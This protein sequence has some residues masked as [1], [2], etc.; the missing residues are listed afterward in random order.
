[1]KIA[2]IV[3]AAGH[4]SRF[5]GAHKLLSEIGGV[6]LV[7]HVLLNVAT[8]SIADIVL[9]T[10]TSSAA[11]ETVAGSGRWR[12]VLNPDAGAGLSTSIRSGLAALEPN[13]A[14]ALIVLADMPGVTATLIDR[15]IEAF[16]TAKGE[17][18]IYP[19]TPDGR[20]GHPVLWPKSLFRELSELT[21]DKGGKALLQKHADKCVAIGAG[22]ADV[23]LDIDTRDDL[24]RYLRPH[25]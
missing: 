4:S 2:A 15:L 1:M 14:G 7:R 21:G 25:E 22:T 3:L 8:S 19:Q 16:G 18:I 23:A 6:P 9:V 13:A 17:K 11:V 10:G 5:E 24:A 12:T 20:Q